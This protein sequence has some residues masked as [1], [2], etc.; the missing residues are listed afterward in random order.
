MKVFT[1]L[2]SQQFLILIVEFKKRMTWLQ[3]IE[4]FDFL[5]KN[6]SAV[7]CTNIGLIRINFG[8]QMPSFAV[9]FK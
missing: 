9:D 1:S 8:L 4:K 6:G 7:Y 5:I 2:F 3:I